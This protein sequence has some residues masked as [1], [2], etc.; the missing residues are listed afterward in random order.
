M[1]FTCEL[2]NYETDNKSNF[3]K[4]ISSK[5][6]CTKTNKTKLEK[7]NKPVGSSSTQHQKELKVLEDKVDKYKNKIKIMEK[8][9]EHIQ[10][11]HNKDI[12]YLQEMNNKSEKE[13]TFLHSYL[14]KFW[15]ILEISVSTNKDLM[16]YYENLLN[17]SAD[18]IYN[19]NSEDDDT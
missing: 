16:E 9:F 11:L 6:H 5:K 12:T 19:N 1:S 10:K 4:H 18:N 2:C 8:E 3:T 15:D 13:I 17:L 14:D 7:I